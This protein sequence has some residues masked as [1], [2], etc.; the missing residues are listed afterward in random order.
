MYLAGDGHLDDDG[1][2]A[3]AAPAA[4]R[5]GE[6][7]GRDEGA[8]R[9]ARAGV[10]VH[11]GRRRR[12]PAVQ[13]AVRRRPVRPAHGV[14]PPRHQ[15][16]LQL[17][18][19]HAHHRRLRLVDG[20]R[21]RAEQRELVGRARH[22]GGAHARLLR[23][24]L[25]RRG[26]LRPRAPR[27]EPLRRRRAR[28]RRRVPEAVGRR[29]L[30]RRRVPLP[31]APR[32]RRR[33]EAPLHRPVQVPRQ[34]RRRGR[35]QERGGRRRAPQE[36]MAAVQ[37][38]AGGG[39][40]VHPPRRPRVA[41][42]HRLLR[43]VRA[44][45][46]LRHPPGGAVRPPPRRRRR[47]REL[48]GA[49]GLVHRLPHAG[50]RRL[51][52]AL[53][54]PRRAMGAPPHGARGRH[55]AAPAD[56]RRHGAVRP[57]HA[58]RRHGREAAARPRRRLAVEHR[59]GVAAVGVLAGA[60]ARRAGAIGG[61]Q[62]GEPDGVLLQGVPGEHAERRR[63]GAVQRAGAVELPERGAGRRRGARH[64]GRQRRGRRRV[65]RR[66]PE[67]G[68]AGLVLPPHRRHWGGQLLGV[69]RVRQVVQVQGL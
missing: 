48:R 42:L 11:R 62:P 16:L 68:E 36:S 38:P 39:G 57:R 56:G 65:A 3:G 20:D 7:F 19:L 26:A 23:P 41:H 9:G 30:R 4:V 15:Q 10:R 45:E 53:R 24:L 8:A 60:A 49:T 13:P 54:P 44:D 58:R 69:R 21:L 29:A 46:H 6:V 61:V 28:R 40:Q 25:R 1:R 27:G 31:D 67:Q 18:L 35:R 63:V 2:R 47:R 51:D 12:D 22:P 59:P 14:R 43:R 64:E 52:P 33:V 66:G 32:Q 37:P 50:A 17:V 34:G 5:R 55:H